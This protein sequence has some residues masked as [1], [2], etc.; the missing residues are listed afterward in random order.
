MPIEVFFRKA[1]EKKEV[2]VA[3]IRA[4][5]DMYEG[6]MT[7]VKAQ[8]GAIDDFLMTIGLHRRSNLSPYL[9]TLVLDVLTENHSR[10]NTPMY[11][12]LQMLLS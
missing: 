1:L 12:F 11:V 8:G 7:S 3:Y 4:I 5:K 2:W 9:F 10:T 6:C